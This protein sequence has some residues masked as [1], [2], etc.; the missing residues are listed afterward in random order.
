LPLGQVNHLAYGPGKVMVIGRNT[1]DPA[2]WKRYK[3]GT[4]GHLWVDAQGSGNFRRMS[5]IPGNV[6]SPM[7]IRDRVYFISDA[8]GVGNLYSIRPDG[9]D[10]QRHTDHDDFYAR[11][12]QTD[13][14]R[15]VY[16]CGAQ[17]WL[18]DPSSGGAKQV[19][20]RAPAHRPQA[21]RKFVATQDFLGGFE[22]HPQGHSLAVD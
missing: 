3:G 13:G 11:H 5:E 12:A 18:F 14:K 16:Q 9:S 2:R 4:A 19:P 7:W 8:E 1:A 10:M 15:V 6:T 21:A 17:I 22:L 20:L